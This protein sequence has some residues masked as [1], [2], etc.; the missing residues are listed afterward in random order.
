MCIRD[1]ISTIK[2]EIE[3]VQ[4][5]I[6]QA[7]RSFDLNK[8]AE[9]EF[10]TLNSLQKNL[11]EKSDYLVNSHKNG[12]TSLLRQEVT[13]DDIAEVVSK[14]TSIPVKDLNQSEKDRLLS[15]E[16][17]LKEKIIGQDNAIKAVADTIKRSRTG[18]NDPSKPLASFL[19][20]GPTGVGKT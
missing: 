4:L 16:S 17:V 12:E 20:L 3:S 15:L 8:A 1:R 10:G 9:L 14:W 18:L 2:E 7:K 19:F 11:K 6:D 13:F 5:Q